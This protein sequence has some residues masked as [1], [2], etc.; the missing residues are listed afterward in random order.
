[1]YNE[2]SVLVSVII[3]TYNSRHEICD[4]LEAVQNEDVAKEIFV[5]DNGSTD[6]TQQIIS[7]YATKNSNVTVIINEENNGLAYANN[8]PV[9]DCKG[10]YLLILNPDTVVQEGALPL[11]AGYLDEHADVGV[12][13]P[14][15]LYS[16]GSPHTSYHRHWTIF[17][18][19]LWRIIPYKILRT[20][21]DRMA[22]YK[23][24][25]VYFVSGACLMMERE[26]FNRIG[27]YD[28]RFFLSVEDAADLCLRVRKE[29]FKTVFYP[30]AKIVHLGGRS[31]TQVSYVALYRSYQGAVYFFQKHSGSGAA[32]TVRTALVSIALVRGLISSILSR[33]FKARY[34]GAAQRYMKVAGAIFREA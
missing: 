30:G 4:C 1:M 17:Q 29:G 13:G 24:A 5:V 9:G 11:L 2:N 33:L 31:A 8:Q 28:V 32:F 10:R 14:M 22:R 19:L 27:G 16:D 25:S 7:D 26:L 20:L 34:A 18:A 12:V 15:N 6:G 21:Y 3:V 23:E